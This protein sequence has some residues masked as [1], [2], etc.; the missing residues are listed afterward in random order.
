MRAIKGLMYIALVMIGFVLISCSKD[1]SNPVTPLISSKFT[2]TLNGGG[3]TNQTISLTSTGGAVY[4]SDEDLTAIVFS[5]PANDIGGL[6]IKGKTTGTF[7]IDESDYEVSINMT[8]NFP[9]VLTSGTIVV[10]GFGSVGGEVKGTFSGTS[11]NPSTLV[12]VQVTN[13]SFS[14]KRIM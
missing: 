12:T 14:A 2:C 4:N 6:V 11:I 9:L 7:T 8:G 3:Y 5:S 10:T 13:G 1:S